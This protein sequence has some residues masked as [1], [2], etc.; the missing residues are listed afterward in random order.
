MLLNVLSAVN[1]LAVYVFGIVVD[2]WM[3]EF[4]V[5]FRYVESSVSAPPVFVS[6]E[7]SSDVNVEPFSTRFVVDAVMNDPYVVDEYANVCSAVHEFALPRLSEMV[8]LLPPSRAPSVPDTESD[9][10]V[11]SDVVATVCSEPLP[12]TVYVAPLL[13]RFERL[14]MF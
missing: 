1:V 7:P 2:E 14:V 5:L 4:V 8:E 6:P 13:V 10:L 9:E 11:A 12:P 3:N